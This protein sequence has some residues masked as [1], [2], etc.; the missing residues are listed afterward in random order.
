LLALGAVVLGAVA[1][2]PGTRA[3]AVDAPVTAPVAAPDAGERDEVLTVQQ[4]SVEARA[5][6]GEAGPP[7]DDRLLAGRIW[8]GLTQSPRFEAATRRGAARDR[9]GSLR[10]R[11]R[12]HA[13]YGLD[14]QAHVVRALA[15][16]T[17]EWSD[18]DEGPELWS[19]VA[20]DGDAPKDA[21]RLPDVAAALVEC[22]IGRATTELSA[23]NDLR[24]GDLPHLLAALD[25]P[26]PALRQVALAAIAERHLRAA[27]PR[28]LTLLQSS[29]A[30]ARDGAIGALVA[31]REP[32][33]VRPLTELAEFKDLDL[34]RRVID[35]VGAI[36][37]DEAHAYLELVAT[38]HP[39]PI[40]RELAQQ[41]LDRLERR[42]DGG[43]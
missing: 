13:A 25:Q 37:G 14:R 17:V 36:G 42:R 31:L 38:G 27:T 39:T 20:C 19:S 2:R 23:R 43:P 21:K 15:T 5:W 41:A 29:D 28:L 1:C 7:L 22:A 24:R 11:V 3:A 18:D 6:P 4:I 35:A 33:A 9:P 16:L 10:R 32:R 26:D 34:M 12:L 8:E 30:T 40:I